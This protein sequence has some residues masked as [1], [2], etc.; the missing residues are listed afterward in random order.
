MHVCVYV[1][2]CMC[3][4]VCVFF[5]N[6]SF[7]SEWFY[8]YIHTYIG[9]GFGSGEGNG[10]GL[11][12][13]PGLGA[14]SGPG[15]GAGL[16]AGGGPGL[17]GPGL[18]AGWGTGL[19][20]GAG[21]GPGLGAGGGPGLGSGSGFGTGSGYGMSAPSYDTMMKLKDIQEFKRY[22]TMIKV[23]LTLPIGL[24]KKKKL[25]YD[26]CPIYT[27]P[28]KLKIPKQSVA[29]KMFSE[30]VVSS[31][32]EGV[33]LLSADPDQPLPAAFFES[34]PKSRKCTKLK[35]NFSVGL[36]VLL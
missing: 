9:N 11:G 35:Y 1:R 20:L 18:G 16:G 5:C 31:A 13:G 6:L 32:E 26:I 36:I 15:F 27:L 29:E 25:F 19:G 23:R 10:M 3:V 21:G 33:R 28:N 24:L 2:V 8:S 22:F 7:L 34:A 30:G 4:Y 14:G 12:F 17:G